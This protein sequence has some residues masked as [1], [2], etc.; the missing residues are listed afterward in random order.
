[1]PCQV[2]E[3]PEL[4]PCPFCR[5]V[6]LL[7]SDLTGPRW[8]HITH[9]GY[10]ILALNDGG[11]GR[12]QYIDY[13]LIKAWNTRADKV[14]ALRAELAEVKTIV[15]DWADSNPDG[16]DDLDALCHLAELLNIEVQARQDVCPH[17]HQT[18]PGTP[19]NE[20]LDCGTLLPTT[21]RQDGAKGKG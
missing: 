4:L 20:C 16:I 8:L 21:A 14:E 2:K 17:L 19:A 12:K 3:A 11:I 13:R 9:D 6:P 10:C 1:M 7:E 5:A 18:F 15:T